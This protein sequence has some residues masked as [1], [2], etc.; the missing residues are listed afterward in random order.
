MAPFALILVGIGIYYL[1]HFEGYHI[2]I[3]GAPWLDA[4]TFFIVAGAMAGFIR[5]RM[6]RRQKERDERRARGEF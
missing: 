3:R 2:G 5:I 6:Y 1:N 4:P